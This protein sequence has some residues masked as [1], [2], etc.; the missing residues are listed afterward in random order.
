[1]EE[2]LAAVAAIQS[3]SP[4]AAHWNVADYL[5]YDLWVAT[6]GG[7]IAGFLVSR[8]LGSGEGELLNVAVAPG[9]RRNGLGKALI[10][11]SLGEFP[12]GIYLEVRE[13]NAIALTL[14]KSMGFK[15]VTRRPRYYEAPVEAGIVMKFHSC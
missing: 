3:A 11:A 6:A 15:E 14:Y 1:L 4:E 9:F 2:D 7:Q 10:R 5:G 13:S 12:N 8:P